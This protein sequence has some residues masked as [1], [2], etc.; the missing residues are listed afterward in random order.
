[1]NSFHVTVDVRLH[2]AMLILKQGLVWSLTDSDIFINF[3][4][5]KMTLAFCKFPETAKDC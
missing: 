1:V 3:S 4:L 2:I 5:H